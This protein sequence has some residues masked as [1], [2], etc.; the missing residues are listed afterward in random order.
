MEKFVFAYIPGHG[1]MVD[2]RYD[3]APYKMAVLPNGQHVYEGVINRQIVRVVCEFS[4]W[5][6]LQVVNLVPEAEDISL[7]ERVRR[8]NAYHD[9]CA[10]KGQ[11]LILFEVHCNA[12]VSH[13]AQGYEC[14]T[15]TGSTF[16]DTVANVW[17]QEMQQVLPRARNRGEKDKN[18]FVIYRT[19]CPAVLTE[20]FFFD[21]PEEVAE[22]YTPEGIKNHAL[23][24]VR[25][26]H[27]IK[28]EEYEVVS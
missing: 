16:S 7:Q 23:A 18:Y 13:Q 2:G 24:F 27:R 3:T 4:Q 20:H 1:G 14:Y 22:H 17:I 26:M 25:T 5:E 10:A 21:N 28:K 11:T 6:G 15:S 9:F 19:K 12:S 8:V